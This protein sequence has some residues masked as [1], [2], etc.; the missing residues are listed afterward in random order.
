MKRF[1]WIAIAV[2][3]SWLVLQPALA[4]TC[5]LP[6]PDDNEACVEVSVGATAEDIAQDL[7][8]NWNLPDYACS[9]T[10]GNIT[11][12]LE[13]G[14]SEEGERAIAFDVQ[15]DG[16][17]GEPHSLNLIFVSPTGSANGPFDISAEFDGESAVLLRD[18]TTTF[19]DIDLTVQ[20]APPPGPALPMLSGRRTALLLSGLLAAGVAM[21]V[22]RRM[23]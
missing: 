1:A 2:V 4:Q 16:M 18:G 14:Q 7:G 17:G 23:N 15:A 5:P 8:Q 3:A 20:T 11:I 13:A 12:T 19:A 10:G 9:T 6:N 21:L 22:F